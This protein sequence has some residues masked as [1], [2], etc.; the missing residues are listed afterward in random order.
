M[1]RLLLCLVISG[2]PYFWLKHGICKPICKQEFTQASYTH[3]GNLSDGNDS[4]IAGVFKKVL[5]TF[6]SGL[7]PA[8]LFLY[9]FSPLGLFLN[10]IFPA[11]MLTAGFSPLVFFHYCSFTTRIFPVFFYIQ[12]INETKSNQTE[13]EPNLI[14]FNLIQPNLTL[15][16]LPKPTPT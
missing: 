5:G 2:A 7:F 1:K 6:P 8:G 10:V 13:P 4:I 12:K 3:E 16:N 14:N 11:G 15:P 9:A